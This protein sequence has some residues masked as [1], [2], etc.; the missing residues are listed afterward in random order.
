MELSDPA[1]PDTSLDMSSTVNRRKSGRATQKPVLLN[2]DPNISQVSTGNSGKRKRADP[3]A[4]DAADSSDTDSEDEDSD[5]ESD[6]DEEELKERR[7]KAPRP[8]KAPSKSVA[9]KPRTGPALTT[10]LAVRPAING[11]KKIARLKQPRARPVKNAED[12]G[13]GLYYEVFSQGHTLDAVAADWIARWDQNNAEAMCDMINFV[14]KCAGCNSEVDVHDIEDQDNAPSKLGDIQEEYHALKPADYP[15]ISKAKGNAAFRSTLSG[16]FVTLISTC[17]AAGLLYSDLAILENIEV[18]VHTMS[19]ST[20]RPFRHTATVIALTIGSTLCTVAADIADNAAKTMRQKEGEQKKKSVNKERVKALEAKIAEGDRR[21]AQVLD[22][23]KDLFDAVFIHRYRDVDPKIRLEC[24]T[25]LG[26][27]ITTLPDVYFDGMHLRYLGWVLSDISTPTRAE[28]V[29]QLGKL[30]KNKDNTPRL[31]TFT[32]KFRSRIVEMAVRDSEV[33][34]RAS[35]VELLDMIRKTGLLEPDDIDIVGRLIFDTEPRVRKA[36]AGFFAENINDL[37][38]TTFEDL[39]GEEGLADILG[40]EVED[41]FD[42]PR[43]S[44]LKLKCVAEALQSYDAEDNEQDSASSE[45]AG[46]GG[47]IAT[48][49]DSRYA[50]AARTICDG[51]SIAREWEVLAG[52]LLFD[53]SSTDQPSKGA[54]ATLESRCKLN[55]KETILLLEILN[56][57]VKARLS[58][59]VEAE[60]DK[61]G[62]KTKALKE[63]SRGIQESTALHLAKALPQLLKKFGT[64]PGTASAVLRLGQ[65]LNLEIF[66]ELRQDSTKYASL[67]D[68]INKQFL[69]HTDRGVLAEAS[70]ALLHARRFEDLEEVTES[71]VQD[72]WDDT[73]GTLRALMSSREDDNLSELCSTVRRIANLASISDCVAVLDM[74]G[75]LASKKKASHQ[76]TASPLDLLMEL[77]RDPELDNGAGEEADETLIGAT[78]ALLF[79]TMWTVRSLQTAISSGTAVPKFPDIALFA[80]SLETLVDSR[81]AASPVRLAAVGTLLDLYTLFATFR[82]VQIPPNYQNADDI[83][84]LIRHIPT[85]AESLILSTYT[86]LEK[87][88]AKKSRRTLEAAP[89]DDLASDPED[90]SD[91]EDE[92][93]PSHAQQDTLI[94]EKRL[95]EIAGKMVL[96]IVGRILDHEGPNKGK[97]KERLQRN[98]GKLGSNF[99]EV[100][101]YLEGPKPKGKKRAPA[102]R[103]GKKVVKP[104]E[105]EDEDEESGEERQV[106]EGGEEDLREKELV[107]D[108]IVDPDEESAE[109]ETARA[110]ADEVEDDNVMGD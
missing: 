108:R 18:W 53:L 27:W 11:I 24:V 96:A 102:K 60:T 45:A 35:T 9:K 100:L 13:T 61:K 65:V 20:L 42:I 69:T 98:K 33:S 77:I 38:E 25:A 8:K 64:N 47:L 79:Y 40:E 104:V 88:F 83:Q 59:A 106:E 101:A 36:V 4:Q 62:H 37:Y 93:D 2:K 19:S 92:D 103:G 30:F 21:R 12:N 89:D 23:M 80:Q 26:N 43:S 56:V 87:S 34:I 15:L 63:Q 76:T 58:E 105:I 74:E 44:W 75:S 66:Q 109:E 31:R 55:E 54:D 85:S 52:Y 28:V 14:I 94:A 49:V 70:T 73:V 51:I 86:A 22:S 107:E 50:L 110:G 39:G 72:L 46:G 91:D 3:P 5:E 17:H 29:K 90:S 82:H 95:C 67:L 68:D 71:K 97:I 84:S 1:T 57:A 41:D 7:R 99:K 78:K 48:G 16:F 6:P 10:S 81:P 32:E